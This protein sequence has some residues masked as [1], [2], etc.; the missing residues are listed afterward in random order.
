MEFDS[1]LKLILIIIVNVLFFIS[2]IFLNSLVV[3]GFWSSEQ[4][5]K[6]TCHFMILVLSSCDLLAILTNHPLTAF[7]AVFHLRAGMLNTN[8]DKIWTL[9]KLTNIFTT[10]SL[11]ALLVM[12]FDRYLAICY[13]IFHRRSIT[14]GRLL[15]LLGI[16]SCTLAIVSFCSAF[17]LGISYQAFGII[18]WIVFFPPVFIFNFRLLKIVRK[19]QR[20]IRVNSPERKTVFAMKQISSILLAVA[21][22]GLLFIPTSAYIAVSVTKENSDADKKFAQLWTTSFVSMNS[23]F[24]CLIFFW[25]NRILR[26]EGMKVVKEMKIC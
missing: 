8:A 12:N 22:V 23:T 17:G 16:L 21:C 6:K 19:S 4:L 2:G 7:I 25:K 3:L 13:P 1:F 14:K 10:F 18:F 15:I 11:T 9:L 24:N 26:T 5:R 20:Q